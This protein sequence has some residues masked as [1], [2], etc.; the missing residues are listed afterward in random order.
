MSHDQFVHDVKTIK[1][2][3]AKINNEDAQ[4][5]AD[6]AK[7]VMCVLAGIERGKAIVTLAR[8]LSCIQTSPPPFPSE[9]GD[10]DKAHLAAFAQLALY[11]I[12]EDRAFKKTH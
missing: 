1:D 3:M 2:E 11:F 6:L 5:I 9:C 7:D 10:F 12:N 8:V 4:G